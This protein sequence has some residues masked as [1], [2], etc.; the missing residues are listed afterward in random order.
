MGRP[1]S[2]F[3]RP[4]QFCQHLIWNRNI[5]HDHT[6]LFPQFHDCS[7]SRADHQKRPCQWLACGHLPDNRGQRGSCLLLVESGRKA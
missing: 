7:K 5:T 3:K 4:H 2:F 1:P 6:A